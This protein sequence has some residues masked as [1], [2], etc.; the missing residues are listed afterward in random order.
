MKKIQL[1]FIAAIMLFAIK[2]TA[3]ISVN[4]NLGA[5]PVY[6]APQH[7]Y[8]DDNVDY[9]FLPEIEAY[10]DNREGLFIYFSTNRWVRSQNLPDYCGDF[11]INRNQRIAIDYHGNSPFGDFENHRNRYCNNNSRRIIYVDNSC[12]SNN[13]YKNKCKKYKKNKHNNNHDHDD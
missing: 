12:D 4:I 13:K 3:Q 6:H 10:F 8:Y 5:R 7:Y 11:N 1:I 2:T 9:Y